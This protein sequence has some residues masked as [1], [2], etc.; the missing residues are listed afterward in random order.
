MNII[1]PITI[2]NGRVAVNS[3]SGDIWMTQHEI[4]DLFGVFV[5]AV[6]TN[7]R[8]IFKNEVLDERRARRVVRHRN[9]NETTLYNLEMITALAFRLTSRNAELFRHWIVAQAVSPS[10][11][12]S[13]LFWKIQSADATVN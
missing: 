10:P 3:V 4:A 9:G 13:V 11:S 6:G 8:S 7:I 1:P 5:S 12:T 2:D